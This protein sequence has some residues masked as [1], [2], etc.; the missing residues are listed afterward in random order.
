M[1]ADRRQSPR[2]Q[3]DRLHQVAEQALALA[4]MEIADGWTHVDSDSAIGRLREAVERY[5]ETVGTVA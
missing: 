4:A 3:A 5:R 2:R 1:N